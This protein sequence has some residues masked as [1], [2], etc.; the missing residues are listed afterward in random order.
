[1]NDTDEKDP[2]AGS[3]VEN[4]LGLT[5][6]RRAAPRVSVALGVEEKV[7]GMQLLWTST[8]LSSTGMSIRDSFSRPV[9]TRLT[10]QLDLMDGQRPLPVKCEVVDTYGEEGGVRVRFLELSEQDTQ[11]IE[12]ALQPSIDRQAGR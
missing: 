12:R 9:G 7:P 1:V 2:E 4:P 11:R 3:S 8:D 5:S 10:L 6:D